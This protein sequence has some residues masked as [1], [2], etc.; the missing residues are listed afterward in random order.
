[1]AVVEAGVVDDDMRG[2]GGRDLDLDG[3]TAVICQQLQQYD[4]RLAICPP[5]TSHSTRVIALYH[6][7]AAAL[8]APP[9]QA[10]TAT[11]PS[12]AKHLRRPPVGRVVEPVRTWDGPRDPEE[13]DR[14][15]GLARGPAG[16]D[17]VHRPA[18]VEH[19]QPVGGIFGRAALRLSR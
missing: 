2:Q 4:G 16:D 12:A 7:T 8:A 13:V 15:V 1:V 9:P 18:L 10:H 19:I 6:T 3:K 11:R 5:K 14:R 17:R